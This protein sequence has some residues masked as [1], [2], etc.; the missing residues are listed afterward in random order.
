MHPATTATRSAA[1]RQRP[2]RAASA[3]GGWSSAGRRQAACLD[4]VVVH[5]SRGGLELR[6]GHGWLKALLDAQGLGHGAAC[7][8][9]GVK[10]RLESTDHPLDV[11]LQAVR[12][13]TLH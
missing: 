13:R 12:G 1:R 3:S 4:L 11:R 5:G 8:D 10:E 9:E 2:R 6:A 7:L